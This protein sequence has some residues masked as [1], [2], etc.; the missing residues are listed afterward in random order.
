MWSVGR[1]MVGERSKKDK[2]LTP[3]SN[4]S[5]TRNAVLQQLKFIS[6]FIFA[7]YVIPTEGKRNTYS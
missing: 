5:V 1:N 4:A 6:N 7:Y 2:L 3:V